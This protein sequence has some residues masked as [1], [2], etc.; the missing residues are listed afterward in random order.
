MGIIDRYLLR[1]FF[2]TFLIF[3]CSLMGLYVIIESTTNMEEFLRCGEKVGGV[4][5]LIGRYYGYR[6]FALFDRINGLLILISAMFTV[7]WIQRHNEMTA[8]MAAGISRI[9][10]VT[11]LI[12]ASVFVTILAAAN[13]EMIIPRFREELSRRPQDLIGDKGQSLTAQYDNQ[14]DVIIGGKLSY[15]EDKRIESPEFIMPKSLPQYG[16]QVRADNAYYQPPQ[17]D[18]PGGYL[19]DKVHEPKHLDT[20]PSL[21]WAGR[22]VLITPHDRPEWLMPN[23]CFIVSDLDFEQLTSGKE[24]SSMLQL[25]A[26]LNNSSVGYDAQTRVAVHSRIVQPFL[27]I[28]LLFLGLPLVVRRESHNVFLAV[29]MCIGI[30][31]VFFLT[32]MGFQQLGLMIS[33]INP[34][35]AAWAP[36]MIFVPL[37]VGLAHS[38]RE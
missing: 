8:L 2:K 26:G 32:V 14:T 17:G 24:F 29:G 23:Q 5:T 35:L 11:P 33:F 7:S 6:T 31:T 9:R 21:L 3:F 19:F 27:D 25:I 1:Q 37:A 4:L 28:T 15:A 13:R 10:V 30:T 34:A 18:R 12:A 38:M 36:L 22:P 20:R 16:K